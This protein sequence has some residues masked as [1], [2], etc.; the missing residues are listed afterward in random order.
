MNA[1]E[2]FCDPCKSVSQIVQM[3]LNDC[4]YRCESYERVANEKRIRRVFLLVLYMPASVQSAFFL[5]ICTHCLIHSAFYGNVNK[6]T[7]EYLQTSYDHYKCLANNKNGLQI[8]INMLRMV[9][10]MLRICF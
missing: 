5:R 3:T 7:S 2:M 4:E 8:V 9:T 1:C 6:N 10:N